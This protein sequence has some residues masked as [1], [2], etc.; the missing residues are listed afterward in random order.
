MGVDVMIAGH[1]HK[2]SV[3]QGPEGGLYINPGSVRMIVLINDLD[4]CAL[5]RPPRLTRNCGVLFLQCQATGCAPISD[6]EIPPASFV[7]ID[8]Q[9]NKIVTYSYVLQIV[10]QEE[11]CCQY[12]PTRPCFLL[13]T[14]IRISHLFISDDLA[15]S[16]L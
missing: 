15:H 9:G 4:F 2:L 8:V 10:G 7:L 6:P 16:F 13:A 11:V 5:S 3:R 12:S 1:T 14:F